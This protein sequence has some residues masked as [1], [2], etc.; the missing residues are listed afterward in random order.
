[1]LISLVV[2]SG[3]CPK[4]VQ[5]AIN[6]VKVRHSLQPDSLVVD[7]KRRVR[8]GIGSDVLTKAVKDMSLTTGS[9]GG[10]SRAEVMAKKRKSYMWAFLIRS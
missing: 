4:L 7:G 10:S 2:C 5:V 9:P 8:T 1:M 6:N 3:S